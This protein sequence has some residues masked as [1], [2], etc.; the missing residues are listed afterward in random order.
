MLDPCEGIPNMTSFICEDTEQSMFRTYTSIYLSSMVCPPLLDGF[1]LLW[2]CMSS[3][4]LLTGD[5][6]LPHP[7]AIGDCLSPQA[8]LAREI[9]FLKLGKARSV[10]FFLLYV[11]SSLLSLNFLIGI[12]CLQ[13]TTYSLCVILHEFICKNVLHISLIYIL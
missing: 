12:R 3:C 11:L 4:L 1:L 2:M 8:D 9:F 5:I 6:Y 10:I 13:E 7:P